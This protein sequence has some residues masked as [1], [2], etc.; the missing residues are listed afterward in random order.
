VQ[1]CMNM[2]ARKEKETSCLWFSPVSPVFS[3]NK[4]DNPIMY[5]SHIVESIEKQTSPI[6]S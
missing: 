1:L 6:R 4:T 5:Y 3:I 2:F